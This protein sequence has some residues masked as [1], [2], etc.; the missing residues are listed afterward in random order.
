[1]LRCDG[2]LQVSFLE[3]QSDY[4]LEVGRSEGCDRSRYRSIPPAR[5]L[6]SG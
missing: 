3:L 1:M 6:A 4:S 2:G 5:R